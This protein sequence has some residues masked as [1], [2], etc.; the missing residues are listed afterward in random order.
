[1]LRHSMLNPPITFR[2]LLSYGLAALVL[3]LPGSLAYADDTP[4]ALE[5]I[6]V[7]AAHYVPTTNLSATKI[8]IPLIE[9]PQAISV[10]TR[11]QIDVLNFQ[12]L[13]QA[14]RYTAGIIGENFGPDERYDWLTL[15]GFQPV[16]YI[17]GLQAPIGSTSNVGIDLWGA[18][19]VEI[20]KGP[21]GVLYGQTP[22]GGIVN[23]TTRRPEMKQHGEIQAQYGSFDDKQLAGDV[24]GPIVS[25]GDQSLSGRLTAMW[26]DRGIQEDFVKSRRIY[27]APSLTWQ[28]SQDTVLTLLSYYQTDR[29]LGDGG[30]FLPAVG[31]ILP[32]P[33]GQI[34]INFDAGEPG[35]NRFTREQYAFGYDLMHRFNDALTFKQNIKYSRANSYSQSVYGAGLEAD[36]RTLDRY[37]FIFPEDIR[38]VALDQRLEIRAGGETI[39]HVALVGFDF[40][41][42]RNS[43]DLGFGFGPS[44]DI[45]HPVY[46][47][48]IPALFLPTYAY[49]RQSQ[50]QTGVYGQDEI[51]IDHWR[52]TLSARKDWLKTK[53]DNT[54]NEV[55]DSA[56]TYRAG[57][58]YVMDAGLAP[59][60]S[61]STSFLPIAGADFNGNPFVPSK[62]KQV[63]AGV[64][65][66]PHAAPRGVNLFAS[67]ALFDLKEDNVLTNDPGHAFF[68]LQTGAVEVKGLELE[69][70]AR[71]W[72]RLSLNASYAYTDSKVT[73][74]NGPDLGK[75]LPI[76]APQ[77]AAVFADYTQQSG[78]LAG[79]GGG[80]GFRYLG[81]NYGD[82]A[83][84]PVLQSQ[85]VTLVDGLVHYNWHE[86]LF[87]VNASNLTDKVYIQRC[88]S[89]SQ[90]FFASRRNVF[91]T[92]GR[93]F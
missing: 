65:F 41:D 1:M 5:E 71:L 26:R 64:K 67:A 87:K 35:Y 50:K 86:W 12:N 6:V 19:S 55:S 4:A 61:Y 60:V 45:V 14:V 38:Q 9:T 36:N 85:G 72:E 89:M 59:Y 44:L 83:N 40:R 77:K 21:S 10:I 57:L 34:P 32:N 16:E 42:L 23:L 58:N 17:D 7:T 53:D 46:G 31:T 70:V 91:L 51:K 18:Q 25:D 92:V 22:P 76:V 37:N 80:L 11:D 63:E 33:N 93:T 84:T 78:A 90:C 3:A 49:L 68:N 20:L 24:T 82:P 43:S 47:Q 62:G 52:L 81:P 30:G 75:E 74:S 15:R 27:A 2:P 69:F 48:P 54:N 13:E 28:M 8:E 29:L 66:E 56:F 39:Q 73:K 88:S 79:F